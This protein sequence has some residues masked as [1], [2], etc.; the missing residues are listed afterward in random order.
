MQSEAVEGE[1]GEKEG[2]V[3]LP[4]ELDVGDDHDLLSLSEEMQHLLHPGVHIVPL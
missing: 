4:F 3:V 2:E 1:V